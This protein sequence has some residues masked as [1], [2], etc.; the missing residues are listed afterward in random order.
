MDWKGWLTLISA[1]PGIFGLLGL[2]RT[3]LGKTAITADISL[4]L[5]FAMQ[6]YATLFVLAVLV[7]IFLYGPRII[8]YLTDRKPSMRFQRLEGLLHST[9]L[10]VDS[11]VRQSQ[12]G[13]VVT[14][15]ATTK[16]LLHKIMKAL[17]ALKVQHPPFDYPGSRWLIFLTRI[18]AASGVADLK[19]ARRIW[20]EMEAEDRANSGQTA[21]PR[22]CGAPVKRPL[23][24][25]IL[26]VAAILLVVA[27]VCSSP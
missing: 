13:A 20:P 26:L 6:L 16:V 5:S 25:I 27:I 11:D 22:K 14:A 9:M 4:D 17:D 15:A 21:I 7:P 12:Y 1:I 2:I 8:R 24:A 19:W 10:I 18:T 23:Y 3:E